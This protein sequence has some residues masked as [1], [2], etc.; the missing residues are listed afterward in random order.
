MGGTGIFYNSVTVNAGATI[1]PGGTAAGTLTLGSSALTFIRHADAYANFRVSAAVNDKIDGVGTLTVNAGS[2]VKVGIVPMEA[3]T[4][5]QTFDLIAYG[6]TIGGQGF[7]G[8]QAVPPANPHYSWHLVDNPQKISAQIDTFD[9]PKWSGAVNNDW[10][11]ST[12]GVDGTANWET[13]DRRHATKYYAGDI[14]LFDDT[15]NGTGAVPST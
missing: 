6:G 11:I 7:A 1:A 15:A 2:K 10:D 3:L 5:G 13:G 4:A 8:F 9:Y 12:N 14:V